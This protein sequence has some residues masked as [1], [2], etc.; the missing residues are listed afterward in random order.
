MDDED[1]DTGGLR[2]PPLLNAY[3]E[4][5]YNVTFVKVFSRLCHNSDVRLSRTDDPVLQQ[6]TQDACQLFYESC[7]MMY[8]EIP[9]HAS[10]QLVTTD[11][12][13]LTPLLPHPNDYICPANRLDSP[14]PLPEHHYI[15][16]ISVGDIFV[17]RGLV[18]TIA[19]VRP[20]HLAQNCVKYNSTR[21]FLSFFDMSL[22]ST[23]DLSYK[24]HKTAGVGQSAYALGENTQISSIFYSG[25][26]L[27]T[28]LPSSSTSCT[29]GSSIHVRSVTFWVFFLLLLFLMFF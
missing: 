4:H 3:V 8:R 13:H 19:K 15:D 26:R 27:M 20:L 1:L 6:A 21:A 18:G 7:R 12:K 9:L 28:T 16:S 17:A 24:L 22:G 23:K 10:T 2:A 5:H 14:P 25:S 11:L 29:M